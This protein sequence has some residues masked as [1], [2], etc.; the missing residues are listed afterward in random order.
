M[1]GQKY[2]FQSIRKYV[3][4]VGTLFND[5]I[6]TKTD[7][8]GNLVQE[9][10]VPIT[11]SPKDK[12]LARVQE[13]PNLDRPTATI[14]LPMMSFEMTD[15]RYD[16]TRKINTIG[17]SVVKN[18]P[19]TVKYQYNPVPYNI[20]FKLH[21]YVKNAEDGT[22][23]VEQIL[24][25]FTPDFTVTVMLIPELNEKKDI[26]VI[27]NGIS[28]DDTYVGDF[29]SQRTIIWTLDFLVKGY[30]YGPI[31]NSAIIKYANTVFYTPHVADGK[32]PDAVG[33][34]DPVTMTQIQ[35][36]LTANGQPTSNISL[37]VS[38][39]TITVNDDFGFIITQTDFE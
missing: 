18:D 8:S 31:K 25:Y 19:S 26:P 34:T 35:P 3:S 2:Y 11:Y 23:I 21:I 7:A 20:S 13:D 15:I 39:T 30:I 9:L 29:K 1:F 28:Q 27:L 12:M 17:R 32:L 14:T 5:I 38:A 22:K 24:P 10:K 36:G 4:L 37:S 33:V 6:I 16:S